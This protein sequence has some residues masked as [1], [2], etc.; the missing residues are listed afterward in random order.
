MKGEKT[1][2]VIMHLDYEFNYNGQTYSGRG[3]DIGETIDLESEAKDVDGLKDS[4][5]C[6]ALDLTIDELTEEIKAACKFN[7]CELDV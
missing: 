4:A 6:H 1:M 3:V 2:G 5:I 7:Y